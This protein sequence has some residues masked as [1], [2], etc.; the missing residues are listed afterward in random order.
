MKKPVY[1]AVLIILVMSV[2]I[3]LYS[4]RMT[5]WGRARGGTT[6]GPTAHFVFS[7]TNL[8]A[9]HR[10]QIE[11]HLQN[12]VLPATRK[13]LEAC[14]AAGIRLLDH[15]VQAADLNVVLMSDSITGKNTRFT[16]GN[17]MLTHSYSTNH[18][19]PAGGNYI[20]PLRVLDCDRI[21]ACGLSG[22]ESLW[23]AMTRSDDQES[24]WDFRPGQVPR[25]FRSSGR[26]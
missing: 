2:G 24:P 12:H 17:Y 6:S 16:L 11:G 7:S 23:G 19:I 8:D 1:L 13:F 15:D 3:S 21:T 25:C 26:N 9:S 18:V 5:Q 10:T 20:T 22:E 4:C 14:R